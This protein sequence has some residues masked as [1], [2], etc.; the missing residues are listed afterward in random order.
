MAIAL[1]GCG[2][3][4]NSGQTASNAPASASTT[5]NTPA[6]TLPPPV[7]QVPP[8]VQPEAPAPPA[9]PADFRSGHWGD[10]VA[11]IIASE[12]KPAFQS[13]GGIGYSKV[14]V[15]GLESTAIFVFAD[16]KL[17]RGGYTFNNKHAD[18]NGYLDDYASLDELLS[19]KYGKPKEHTNWRDD[20]YKNT[21][22]SW[23]MAVA[24]GHLQKAADWS[25]PGT[26]IELFLRGDNFAVTLTVAYSSTELKS[27]A[28]DANKK[29]KSK[30]L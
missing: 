22:S 1:T 3:G 28:E 24:A 13:D 20:L 21:P 9:Q 12:G 5:T 7:A 25:L 29:K 27:L 30:G 8:V 15:G 6:P 10:P 2:G 18:N 11:K 17:V 19:A 16:D 4:T 23:G 14:E 26:D